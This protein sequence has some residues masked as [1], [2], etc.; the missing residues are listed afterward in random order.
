MRVPISV[1][2][3]EGLQCIS[4]LDDLIIWAEDKQ[5]CH[6]SIARVRQILESYGFLINEEKSQTEPS[7]EITWLGIMWDS[8]YLI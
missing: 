5:T 1:A 7:Q 4:Y 6:R 3:E 2:H 8:R